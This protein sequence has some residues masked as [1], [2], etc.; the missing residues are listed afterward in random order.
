MV[1]SIAWGKMLSQEQKQESSSDES[2]NSTSSEE[3]S[4]GKKKISKS[5]RRKNRERR[6]QNKANNNSHKSHSKASTTKAK[7]Q[8]EKSKKPKPVRIKVILKTDSQQH[9]DHCDSYDCEA[10][11]R[12]VEVDR[13][14]NGQKLLCKWATERA[15]FL[16]RYCQADDFL[17]L[18]TPRQGDQWRFAIPSEKITD[19]FRAGTLDEE[20]IVWI[21]DKEKCR[22]RGSKAW[23][24]ANWKIIMGDY[25]NR[26]PRFKNKNAASKHI[27]INPRPQK[28]PMSKRESPANHYDNDSHV[29]MC[30]SMCMTPLTAPSDSQGVSDLSLLSFS[31]PQNDEGQEKEA[32]NRKSPIEDRKSERDEPEVSVVS[33]H[34]DAIPVPSPQIPKKWIKN[35]AHSYYDAVSPAQKNWVPVIKNASHHNDAP[36]AAYHASHRNDAPP[37]AY[38]ESHHNDDRSIS[39]APKNNQRYNAAPR[40]P[41]HRQRNRRQGYGEQRVQ[42]QPRYR[43]RFATRAPSP[44]YGYCPARN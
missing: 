29:S 30:S 38:Q 21:S 23:K 5:K 27:K 32:G 8:A 36:Q 37:A 34:N 26:L 9:R 3:S 7:T 25:T 1:Y 17:L 11:T 18:P 19:M 6:Q 43:S 13:E 12:T 20:R 22:K 16:N 10:F 39:Q 4:K 44:G 2:T 35:A 24:A 40:A 42:L 31:I 15:T 41:H 28:P 33:H 14:D